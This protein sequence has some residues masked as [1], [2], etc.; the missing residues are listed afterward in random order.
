MN[1]KRFEAALRQEYLHVA[2]EWKKANAEKNMGLMA[3]FGGAK[4]SLRR[5]AEATGYTN[6][7]W[8]L[9]EQVL[10]EASP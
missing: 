3:M 1:A 8:T 9:D 6:F 4:Q 5:L 10:K 2:R 7:I